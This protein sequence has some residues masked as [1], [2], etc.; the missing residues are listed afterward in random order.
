MATYSIRKAVMGDQA[1][2]KHMVRQ[3]NL[4]PTTLDW[5]HFLVAEIDGQI[6]GIG[7]IKEYPD[8]QELGSLVTLPEY[9]GRGI[10]SGLINALEARAGRP[11]YLLCQDKMEAYYRRFGYH[12]IGRREIPTAIQIKWIAALPFRLFGVRVLVMRKT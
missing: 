3:E 6:V 7:Q 2:I 12:T 8:C 4:D 10:A 9:R 5:R 1:K 11:L